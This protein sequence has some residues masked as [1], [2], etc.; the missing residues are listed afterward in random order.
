ME[1][2][3][4]TVIALCLGLVTSTQ[5]TAYQPGFPETM[6][7]ALIAW[8]SESIH[9]G[10]IPK[11]QPKEIVF[12][13][14]NN[15][16]EPIVISHLKASCGCTATDYSKQPIGAGET[17][18]IKAQYNAAVAGAFSKTVTVSFSNPDIAAK[19]L[20]FKGTVTD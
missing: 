3:K 12:E 8:K 17:G 11:G 9:V 14:T 16:D 4:I 10:E 6:T 13:F 20:S 1:K 2:M 19:V 15:T 7:K 5:V 18:K